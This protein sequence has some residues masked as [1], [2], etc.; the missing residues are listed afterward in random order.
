MF[1]GRL[2]FFLNSPNSPPRLGRPGGMGI[3]RSAASAFLRCISSKSNGRGH[4][5]MG[6][7]PSLVLSDA[8]VYMDGVTLSALRL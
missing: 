3:G 5:S 6:I 2:A 1:T 8:N 4:R 7:S